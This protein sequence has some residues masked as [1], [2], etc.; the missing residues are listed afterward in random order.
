MRMGNEGGLTRYCVMSRRIEELIIVGLVDISHILL[1]VLVLLL[2]PPPLLL[3]PVDTLLPLLLDIVLPLADIPLL[4]PVLLLFSSASIAAFV[5]PAVVCY[6]A[7]VTSAASLRMSAEWT[8]SD[9]SALLSADAASSASSTAAAE[10]FSLSAAVEI[11]FS[12]AE[13]FKGRFSLGR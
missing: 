11:L 7:S 6:T 13:F 5:S 9:S 12:S 2:L 10:F 3:V 8:R 1:V 4:R